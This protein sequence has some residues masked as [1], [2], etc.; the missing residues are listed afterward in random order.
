MARG[1]KTR[2]REWHDGVDV[3]AQGRLV[4]LGGQQV[5]GAVLD[6]Q[7]PGGPGLGVK[8]VHRK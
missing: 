3:L 1:G 4:L 8:C 7:R 2:R 5:V 6:H